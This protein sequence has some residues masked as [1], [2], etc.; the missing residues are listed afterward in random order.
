MP[1]TDPFRSESVRNPFG[2]RVESIWIP[3]PFQ[4]AR[5]RARSI[6]NAIANSNAIA[7]STSIANTSAKFFGKSHR[8]TDAF[9]I[10]GPGASA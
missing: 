7:S 10:A 2:I 8:H 6:A 4:S 9:C 5:A 1:T 3:S